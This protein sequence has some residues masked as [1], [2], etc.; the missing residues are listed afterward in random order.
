MN[1]PAIAELGATLAALNKKGESIAATFS[2]AATVSA[3]KSSRMLSTDFPKG[4]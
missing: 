4:A 1:V 3:S 2:P